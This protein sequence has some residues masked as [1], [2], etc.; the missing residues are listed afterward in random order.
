MKLNKYINSQKLFLRAQNVIP[1]ASQTFSKSYIS[2]PANQS[3][4][5]LTHGKG[6][7]VWDVDGHKY[8]DLVNGLLPNILGYDDKDVLKAVKNQLT[9]GV[10][11][12]LPTEI[13]IMLSEL[14]VDIIPCAEKVRFG[15]NGSDVTSAAI[16]IARSFTKKKR[17]AVCG[18][19][20]WT[21]WASIKAATLR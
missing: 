16:R 18:G 5:F 13:E 8:I 21:V 4:L 9:K 17:I 10:T 6:G 15:K 7:Y 2:F 1:L 20:K 14:L 11:F 3:P 12:S 19:A